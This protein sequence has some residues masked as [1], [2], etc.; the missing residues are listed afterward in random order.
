MNGNEQ[1]SQETPHLLNK[2]DESP[3]CTTLPSTSSAPDD[4][5]PLPRPLRP[6]QLFRPSAPSRGRPMPRHHCTCYPCHD[7][8]SRRTRNSWCCTTRVSGGASAV[9]RGAARLVFREER[10]LS[11]GRGRRIS[12]MQERGSSCCCTTSTLVFRHFFRRQR[13]RQRS[14]V[15]LLYEINL[16]V[17]LPACVLAHA[18][19]LVGRLRPEVS[20]AIAA[21][22]RLYPPSILGGLAVPQSP[23]F[24]TKVCGMVI[25]SY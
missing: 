19:E 20:C 8:H 16:A 1:S 22:R 24:C 14:L 2:S 13:Q 21:S 17:L 9:D 11:G 4:N 10:V 23:N 15:V 3:C 25:S 6:S 12:F 7:T 18:K 5:P